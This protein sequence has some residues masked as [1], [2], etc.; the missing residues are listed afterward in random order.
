MGWGGVGGGACCGLRL[1]TASSGDTRRTHLEVDDCMLLA[2]GSFRHNTTTAGVRGGPH[3]NTG[4]ARGVG[5]PRAGPRSGPAS[6][7]QLDGATL[8]RT[9]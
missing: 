9:P 5:T 8:T 2:N 1:T 3:A 4:P 6:G 7:V